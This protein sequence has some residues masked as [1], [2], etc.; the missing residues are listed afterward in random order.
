VYYLGE[1]LSRKYRLLRTSYTIFM[2]GLILTALS[3]AIALL[4]KS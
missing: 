3:F 4:Y 1:V 2:V